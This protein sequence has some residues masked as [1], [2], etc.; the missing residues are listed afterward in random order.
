[1]PEPRVGR[2]NRAIGRIEGSTSS[3]GFLLRSGYYCVNASVAWLDRLHVV[4]DVSE[5]RMMDCFDCQGRGVETAAVGVCVSCGAA[6]CAGC[7][8]TRQKRLEQ[9][10]TVGNPLTATT[11]ELLCAPCDQVLADRPLHSVG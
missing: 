8:R 2:R 11:R 4:P 5:E 7:L 10:A 3:A 9:H 6:V 1:V